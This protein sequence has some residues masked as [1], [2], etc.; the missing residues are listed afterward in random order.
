LHNAAFARQWG[1]AHDELADAPHLNNIA[2][3]CSVRF[4]GQP[5]WKIVTSYVTS[6]APEFLPRPIDI[7]RSD[8][9]TLSLCLTRLPDGSTLVTGADI[10]DQVRLAA[11][12]RDGAAPTESSPTKPSSRPSKR[13]AS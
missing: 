2:E 7:E 11:A 12:L 10:T 9:K 1:F 5:T 6:L 8:G 3:A 13:R 4:G